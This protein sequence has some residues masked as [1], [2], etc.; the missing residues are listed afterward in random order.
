MSLF[1][2]HGDDWGVD[3]E[4]CWEFGG[5][6]CW[7]HFVV[8]VGYFLHDLLQFLWEFAFN[9]LGVGDIIIIF[10][11]SQL[12]F[13]LEIILL[14]LVIL[15]QFRKYRSNSHNA[16]IKFPVFPL[17]HTLIDLTPYIVGRVAKLRGIVESNIQGLVVIWTLGLL[18][19]GVQIGFQDV[20]LDDFDKGVS[21]GYSG[22]DCVDAVEFQV[23]LDDVFIEG[24]LLV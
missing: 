8:P 16:F 11:L 17:Y 7:I 20:L 22:C 24:V 2:E 9:F 14:K 3:V 1:D 23:L 4:F 21:E 6:F 12:V 10:I 18:G 13:H 5:N 15:F 19:F